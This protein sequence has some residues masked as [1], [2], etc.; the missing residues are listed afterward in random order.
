MKAWES[1]REREKFTIAVWMELSGRNGP[2]SVFL[3]I[4]IFVDTISIRRYHIF[5]P[6]IY[7]ILLYAYTGLHSIPTHGPVGH[8]MRHPM[9]IDMVYNTAW[10]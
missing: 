6:I 10:V 4:G 7:S 8:G 1:R 3:G 2:G 5:Y 9:Y